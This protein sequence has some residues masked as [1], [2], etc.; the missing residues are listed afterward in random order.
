MNL[1]FRRL[2][3][4]FALVLLTGLPNNAFAHA[5]H[6]SIHHAKKTDGAKGSHHQRR[7]ALRKSK[8]PAHEEAKQGSSP[9]SGPPA[10]SADVTPPLTG[11]PAAVKNALDLLRAGKTS[12]ATAVEVTIADPTAKTLVEWLI[13]RHPDSAVGFNRYAAF[14]ADHRGWPSMG[15][16]R[17]RAE[18]LLWQEHGEA[19]T[20]HAFT[21][22]QPISA[23][24]HFALARALLAEGDRDGA[25]R[26]VREAWRS[27]ELSEHSESD[28]YDAF[29]GLLT[30]EDH[31]ARMDK[32]IGARDFA[33]AM[34]AAHHLDDDAISIVKACIAVSGERK[35]S[36]GSAQRR[37]GGRSQGPWLYAVPSGLDDASRPDRRRRPSA[38]CGSAGNHG[39]SGHG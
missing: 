33:G 16:M 1:L 15:L 14:I 9:S 31:R 38:A 37:V 22:D 7:T 4:L 21:H 6:K 5:R 25:Q 17:R 20:I 10:Q 8:R 24:G 29:R 34:R 39:A 3:G 28:A 30:S 35:K 19:A 12:E 32:R 26:Q 2:T 13:L 18:A 11:D 36:I 23:K 27:D